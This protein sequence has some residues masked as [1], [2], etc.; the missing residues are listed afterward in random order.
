MDFEVLTTTSTP[1]L[2]CPM[3]SVTHRLVDVAQLTIDSK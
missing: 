1:L 3:V 2:K